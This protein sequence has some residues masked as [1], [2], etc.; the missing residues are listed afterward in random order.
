MMRIQVIPGSKQ[1][2][3]RTVLRDYGGEQLLCLKD[4]ARS[5]GK[6]G[7]GAFHGF[8]FFFFF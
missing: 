8:F 5:G 6:I 1:V 2:N 3:W 4:T 7:Q